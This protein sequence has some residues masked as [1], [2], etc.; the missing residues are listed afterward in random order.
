MVYKSNFS[1]AITVK[2]YYVFLFLSN[3]SI[4]VNVLKEMLT[5]QFA[6]QIINLV[7]PSI[8]QFIE[9]SRTFS[10]DH[11]SINQKS[12]SKTHLSSFQ[13]SSGSSG[14]TPTPTPPS[15]LSMAETKVHSSVSGSYI[16]TVDRF[17]MPS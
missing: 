6:S 16:S 15:W 14:T 12:L 5:Y 2:I 3:Y 7:H 9:N 17:F 1:E 4:Q 11:Q 8:F 10:F 13:K